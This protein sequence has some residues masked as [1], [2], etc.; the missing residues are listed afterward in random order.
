[1]WA[2]A[3]RGREPIVLK[4]HQEQPRQRKRLFD[5]TWPRS[6]PTE[7]ENRLRSILEAGIRSWLACSTGAEIPLTTRRIQTSVPLL[8]SGECCMV[9]CSWTET[10]AGKVEPRASSLAELKW[11]TKPRVVQQRQWH[12]GVGWNGQSQACGNNLET[13]NLKAN[14]GRWTRMKAMVGKVP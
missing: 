12:D 5:R 11:K 2:N 9:T 13:R 8:R 4:S 14:T 3:P 7:G 6:L 10:N 1:M